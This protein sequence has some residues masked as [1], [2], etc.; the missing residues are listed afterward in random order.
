[1]PQR[2]PMNRRMIK[3]IIPQNYS[4]LE[5]LR[6]DSKKTVEKTR[7][8]F[9][10]TAKRQLEFSEAESL[11]RLNEKRKQEKI[12]EIRRKLLR[13]LRGK[14]RIDPRD[15][16]FFAMATALYQIFGEKIS[17]QQI[18]MAHSVLRTELTSNS[19]V[20]QA[21]PELKNE[22]EKMRFGKVSPRGQ[23]LLTRTISQI[24]QR[25]QVI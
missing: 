23:S 10:K 5:A 21:N 20:M 15:R 7:T 8:F 2:N 1:M 18:R 14:Q 6:A 16:R 17:A 12:E 13:E 24:L 4:K 11:R 22:I 3:P 9:Q 19:S 25:H